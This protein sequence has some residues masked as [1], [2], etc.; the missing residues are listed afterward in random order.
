MVVSGDGGRTEPA[1]V[2]CTDLTV[3]QSR[4]RGMGLYAR[5]MWTITGV[6]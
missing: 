6:P 5:R 1:A 3:C 4:P 2:I